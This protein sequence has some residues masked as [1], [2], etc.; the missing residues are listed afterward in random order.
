MADL[1]KVGGRTPQAVIYKGESQA[2][3][4]ISGKGR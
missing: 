1:H 2:A 4:G 3:S